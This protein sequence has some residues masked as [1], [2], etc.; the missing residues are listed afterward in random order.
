MA[1]HIPDDYLYCRQCGLLTTEHPTCEPP[2]DMLDVLVLV[3]RRIASITV[4]HSIEADV[5]W[6]IKSL[7]DDALRKRD[8]PRLYEDDENAA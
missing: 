2:E 5:Q 6:A 3:K 8:K 4:T 7:T 1:Q